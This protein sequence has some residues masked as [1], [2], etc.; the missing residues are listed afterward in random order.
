MPSS[1]KPVILRNAIAKG[2]FYLIDKVA[3]LA[4]EE[5][6]PGTY[7]YGAVLNIQS[8]FQ[9]Y[10]L[11]KD[12]KTVG[13]AFETAFP[14]KCGGSFLLSYQEGKTGK[15][16]EYKLVVRTPDLVI[17]DFPGNGSLAISADCGDDMTFIL[18]TQ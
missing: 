11:L 13:Y 18:E 8:I 4:Q 2:N 9:V 7:Y 17:F 15:A 1:P 10:P 12:N 3:V 6:P 5:L 14:S 16:T